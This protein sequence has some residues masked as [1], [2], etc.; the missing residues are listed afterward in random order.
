[1]SVTSF[2]DSKEGVEIQIMS[3]VVGGILYF[4]VERGSATY[5]LNSTSVGFNQG[6]AFTM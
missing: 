1:M 5:N 6:T 2:A 4:E 3:K